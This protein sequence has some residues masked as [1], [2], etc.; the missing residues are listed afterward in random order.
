VS[1]A[2]AIYVLHILANRDI[3][4]VKGALNAMIVNSTDVQN[5]FGKY[6]ELAGGQEIVITKNGQPVARLLGMQNIVSFLSDSLL[7]L[8][9]PDVNEADEK[10]ERLTRQ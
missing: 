8:I 6:L 1:T 4:T 2:L 10:D 3:L 9:P 7:G 5:N